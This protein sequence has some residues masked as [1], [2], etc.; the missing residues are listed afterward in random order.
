MPGICHG[1]IRPVIHALPK[2]EKMKERKKALSFS[3]IGDDY[4]DHQ[5]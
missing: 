3:V 4:S 1:L 5:S 2:K